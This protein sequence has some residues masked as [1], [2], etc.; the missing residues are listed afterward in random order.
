MQTLLERGADPR[1]LVRGRCPAYWVIHGDDD[2]CVAFLDG[3]EPSDKAKARMLD[4]LLRAGAPHLVR[5]SRPFYMFDYLCLEDAVAV[6]L[7][8]LMQGRDTFDETI[9]MPLCMAILQAPWFHGHGKAARLVRA[10]LAQAARR[11]SLAVSPRHCVPLDWLLRRWRRVLWR[12]EHAPRRIVRALAVRRAPSLPGAVR[13][14]MD[15]E[16]AGDA[17]AAAA[18]WSSVEDAVAQGWGDVP[19]TPAASAALLLR[20]ARA[21]LW[22]QE[23]RD[24]RENAEHV[25]VDV[26][27]LV[28]RMR[29]AP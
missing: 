16:A 19:D 7:L 6:E 27:L 22:M 26:A 1:E 4:T 25:M 5:A 29:C 15:A 9:V 23:R 3:D 24:A 10:S 14:A 17:E 2:V 13:T 18:A 12:P 21:E 28:H 20:L 8:D 11:G